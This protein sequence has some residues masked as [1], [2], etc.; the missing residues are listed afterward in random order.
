MSGNGFLTRLKEI[1][2]D[3]TLLSSDSDIKTVGFRTSLRYTA[4]QVKGMWTPLVSPMFAAG[5]KRTW[6]YSIY[7]AGTRI[8][9]FSCALT[10]DIRCRRFFLRSYVQS[11]ELHLDHVAPLFF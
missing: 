2:V 7:V 3:Q 5:Q 11:D 6:Q 10:H 8:L 9:V 1:A 4:I